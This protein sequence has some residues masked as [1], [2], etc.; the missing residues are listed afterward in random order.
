MTPEQQQW[1]YTQLNEKEVFDDISTKPDKDQ[2][3]ID[4]IQQQTKVLR[5]LAFALVAGT[6]VQQSRQPKP[7]VQSG[8]TA[9][10]LLQ[11][12]QKRLAETKE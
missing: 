2:A 12:A 11:A 8:L 5:V 10:Q 1:C 6:E 7:G 4:A 9:D 3:L